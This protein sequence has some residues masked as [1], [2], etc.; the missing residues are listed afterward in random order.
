LLSKAY[1][2]SIRV[3]AHPLTGSPLITAV[4]PQEK[5]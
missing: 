2:A 5:A 4:P 3:C 1:H